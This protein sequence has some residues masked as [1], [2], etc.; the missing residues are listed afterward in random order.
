[1]VQK[2]FTLVP[3]HNSSLGFVTAQENRSTEITNNNNN[4]NRGGPLTPAPSK[5]KCTV[6]VDQFYY[7]YSYTGSG[8]Q[9]PGLSTRVVRAFLFW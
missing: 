5:K 1:M 6:T 2:N 4:K 3:R 7:S 8:S 9:R